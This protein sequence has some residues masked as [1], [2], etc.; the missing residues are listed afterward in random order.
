[1]TGSKVLIQVHYVGINASDINYSAGRYDPSV[2]PPFDSG[3]EGVGK[4]VKIGPS[5]TNVKVDQPV[6]FMHYGAFA[7]YVSIDS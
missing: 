6:L 5:V 7:E 2:K 4:I 3:F 1:M